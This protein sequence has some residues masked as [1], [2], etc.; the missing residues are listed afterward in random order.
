LEGKEFAAY[1]SKID[2]ETIVGI[3]FVMHLPTGDYKDDKLINLG[4]NRFTFRP[5]FGMV[6]IRGKW[7]MEFTGAVWF[8]TDNDEFFNGNKREQDPL[9]RLGTHL[10]YT[11]RPG[12]WV[13]TSGGYGY[14]AK[15][16]INGVEKND[17]RE[18]LSW[19]FS[20][21]YPITQKLGVK[22][23]YFGSRA[24]EAVGSDSD[25]ITMGFSIFW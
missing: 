21:G 19:S 9:Y 4:S 2:V 22:I 15:S 7:S 18:N 8:F 24:Q 14:G 6:H 1:Q 17:L 12:L 10:V 11:F 3:A 23:A 20:L 25:S 16:T 5:Q 13:A